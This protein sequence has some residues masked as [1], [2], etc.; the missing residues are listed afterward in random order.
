MT[1]AIDE[2]SEKYII[3]RL[4][5][6]GR[7]GVISKVSDNIYEYYIET[8][9]TLEMI[10]WIRTFIGRIIDIEGSEK[11]VILQFKKD[12]STMAE[13]YGLISEAGGDVN[14]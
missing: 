6:E 8:N 5:R 9:D 1:L 3:Q 10:P 7:H 11:K 12:I 2:R 13:M 14:E 4:S